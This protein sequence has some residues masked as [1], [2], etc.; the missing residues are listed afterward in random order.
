MNEKIE[1]SQRELREVR[2]QMAGPTRRRRAFLSLWKSCWVSY[3]ASFRAI[4]FEYDG[5]TDP[6]NHICRFKNMVFLHGF[7]D[8]IKCRVFPTTLTKAAQT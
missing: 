6:W 1:D 5:T 4:P 2:R 7:M 3:P 8:G